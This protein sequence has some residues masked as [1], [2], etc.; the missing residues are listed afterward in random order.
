MSRGVVRS[1]YASLA[2]RDGLARDRHQEHAADKLDDLHARLIGNPREFTYW[3]RRLRRLLPGQATLEPVRGIYL[4][5]GVG[6]GKTLLM[7][8]FYE[9]LPFAERERRHFHRFMREAH[10]ELR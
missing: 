10:D 8:L 1:A 6:R 7:D 9:T 5:G 2:A 4:W 3:A